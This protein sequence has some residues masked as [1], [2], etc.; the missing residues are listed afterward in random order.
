MQQCVC[1]SVCPSVCAQLKHHRE[2]K[3]RGHGALSRLL[4]RLPDQLPPNCNSQKAPQ[5]NPNLPFHCGA[6]QQLH[7]TPQ[8]SLTV[9]TCPALQVFSLLGQPN[10]EAAD[11]GVTCGRKEQPSLHSLAERSAQ[12]T[13]GKEK[14][15][16][17]SRPRGRVW[18]P[19]F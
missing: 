12:V 5:C 14:G 9:C 10:M 16:T 7:Y 17:A 1:V 13:Q 6:Q 19:L 2:T 18:S 11:R 3:C 8:V 15:G 4:C